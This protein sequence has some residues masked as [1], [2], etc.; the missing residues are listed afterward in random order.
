DDLLEFIDIIVTLRLKGNINLTVFADGFNITH[1][2]R[3]RKKPLINIGRIDEPDI[4]SVDDHIPAQ[5]A[6]PHDDKI[7]LVSFTERQILIL[8]IPFELGSAGN[9]THF[10]IHINIDKIALTFKDFYLLLL[11]GN[12][13][14]LNDAPVH[15]STAGQSLYTGHYRKLPYLGGWFFCCSFQFIIVLIY[16]NFHLAANFSIF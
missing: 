5:F 9:K 4:F 11:I 2:I 15:E 12:E 1:L 10:F 3:Q 8:R 13:E 7:H 14:I 6:L 16:E